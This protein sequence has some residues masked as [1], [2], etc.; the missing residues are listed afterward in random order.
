MIRNGNII[1]RASGHPEGSVLGNAWTPWGEVHMESGVFHNLVGVSQSGVIRFDPYNN[2]LEFSNDGGKTFDSFGK[3]TSLGVIGDADLTG[4]IDLSVPNSGFMTIQDTGDAS[5]LSFAVD[6]LGLSGL[7][8][9]PTQG[10]SN[11]VNNIRQ[12][13]NTPLQGVVN[14][15]TKSSG[16]M[17]ITQNGQNLQWQVDYHALS[18]LW[19]LSPSSGIAA[20]NQQDGQYLTLIGD[21]SVSIENPADDVIQVVCSGITSSGEVNFLPTTMMTVS[22]QKVQYDMHHPAGNAVTYRFYDWSTF[23]HYRVGN[24]NDPDY[25][26]SP[27]TLHQTSKGTIEQRAMLWIYN[28]V[29]VD[30]N[31]IAAGYYGWVMENHN[32]QINTVAGQ[33]PIVAQPTVGL[34]SGI[35]TFDGEGVLPYN[36]VSGIQSTRDIRLEATDN[37]YMFTMLGNRPEVNGSGIALLGEPRVLSSINDEDGPDIDIIGDDSISIDVPASDVIQVICSGVASSGTLL[38]DATQN[39]DTMAGGNV[40]HSGAGNFKTYVYNKNYSIGEASGVDNYDITKT[41]TNIYG[42]ATSSVRLDALN[43]YLYPQTNLHVGH[44]SKLKDKTPWNINFYTRNQFRLFY[45]GAQIT[46]NNKRLPEGYGQFYAYMSAANSGIP[47]LISGNRGV[48]PWGAEEIEDSDYFTHATAWPG[49]NT[50]VYVDRD[51]V[52]EITYTVTTDISV[53]TTRTGCRGQCKIN[54]TTLVP[55]S[56]TYTYNRTL[57]AGKDTMTWKGTQ[58]LNSG[59]SITVEVVEYGNSTNCVAV[60]GACSIHVKWVRDS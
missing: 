38:L 46:V 60:Q 51:G 17:S 57:G 52:Y 37:I 1:P 19:G 5:P 25:H 42:F 26:G 4:D 2:G 12:I 58:E 20:V 13:G 49:Y 50:H 34:S 41:P 33:R 44:S 11:V 18:G 54:N 8:R 27:F 16:F 10:L 7:W 32:V 28:L 53:G 40:L 22:G 43:I 30:P 6:H 29:R 39:F 23:G 21:D 59:D 9:F 36:H 56:T 3:I 31:D 47:T 15:Q 14:F 45:D 24:D 55:G 35:A 48:I